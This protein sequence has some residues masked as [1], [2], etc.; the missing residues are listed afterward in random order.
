MFTTRKAQQWSC[1]SCKASQA[2]IKLPPPQTQGTHDWRLPI[3]RAPRK[4]EITYTGKNE[5]LSRPPDRECSVCGKGVRG[6]IGLRIHM[7]SHGG[8]E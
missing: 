8:V 4:I 3:T 6:K 1:D 7:L 2:A 5:P